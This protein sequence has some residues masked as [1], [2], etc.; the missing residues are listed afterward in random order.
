MELE[1]HQFYSIEVLYIHTVHN[2]NNEEPMAWIKLKWLN[3]DL[4]EQIVPRY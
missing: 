3:D 1:A 2:S 4:A